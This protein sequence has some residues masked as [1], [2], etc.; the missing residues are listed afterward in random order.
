MRSN[1]SF[2]NG[3][4]LKLGIASVFG[5]IAV[6]AFWAFG[7][8][9]DG[10]KIP[11]E[12]IRPVKT[13]RVSTDDVSEKRSFPGL[14]R[15][16]RETKLAFRVGGPL[17][18]LN[19]DIGQK[20]Q[21]DQVI[22]RIDPRDFEVNINRLKAVV[23]QAEANFK[24]LKSGA[25]SEDIARLKAQ[26][27]AAKV[28]LTTAENDFTRQ[29]N[30]LADGAASKAKYDNA[31]RV[32]EM[33]KANLASITQE[34]KKAQKGGRIEE[35]EAAEA[36]LKKLQ[37]DL[38]AAEHALEDST[39]KAP[40]NGYVSQKFVENFENVRPG[41]P[42][43][44]FIDL[45]SVEVH[46]AVPEDVIIRMD[47]VTDISCTLSA[48]PGRQ[49]EAAV[50]EIGRETDSANQSYPL[51]V[52]LKLPENLM[53]TP[54]MAAT[55]AVSLA[56]SKPQNEGYMLP[57]QAIF[58]D[59]EG[60]TCVFRIDSEKMTVVKTPVTVGSPHNGAIRILSGLSDGDQIVTAG[61]KF[62]REN[63]KVRILYSRK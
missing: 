30:L 5:I 46:A 57:S 59:P 60:Q 31:Q 35:V 22:A 27:A 55:L 3:T 42:V 39:L 53:V 34:L 25:R 19:V 54:G 21:K 40:Y 33:A 9:S 2:K 44:S 58:A 61:A 50:K 48:Y 52:E 41:E 32:Y 29:K 7:R 10:S 17:I 1:R 24:A 51:T 62:L 18:N 13:M 56:S 63:Q 28:Q 12:I 47:Q 45:S 36:G 15:P 4:A 11:E 20:V 14:V 43:V 26:K 38:A 37:A 8:E 23:S 16:L 6:T 49:F